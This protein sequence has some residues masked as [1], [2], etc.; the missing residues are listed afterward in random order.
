MGK[1]YFDSEKK[2]KRLFIGVDFSEEIKDE[3]YNFQKELKK[4]IN[5]N[6]KWVE[7]ENFHLTL[8]F[9]GEVSE[10]LISDIE[11]IM[12]EVSNYVEPFYLILHGFGAFPSTSNPRVLWIG[13]KDEINALKILFD[14]L[15]R[16][17]VKKGFMKE[18]KPFSPHLTLGRVKGR[19]VSIL[20]S[21]SFS[22][23]KVFVDEIILFESRLTQEGPIYNPIFRI[24]L[25]KK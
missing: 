17:L 12:I 23:K 4:N 7:R 15:E 1:K 22:E 14:L 20:G 11:E 21:F 18:E 9:L 16:R 24:K 10:E 25:G 13:V 19:D 2:V 6:I 8:K 3:I 5:G